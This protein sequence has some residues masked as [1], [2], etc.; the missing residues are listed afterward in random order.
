M[1]LTHV[2]NGDPFTANQV[3]GIMD[4]IQNVDAGHAHSGATDDGHQIS[5]ADLTDGV[6]SGRTNSHAQIDA[7]VAAS[8]GIHGL[9]ASTKLQGTISS[10]VYVFEY[11]RITVPGPD[12]LN[13]V[14]ITT[15]LSTLIGVL[16]TPH[17]DPNG[18]Q[19]APIV[20]SKLLTNAAGAST[21]TVKVGNTSDQQRPTIPYISW[22]A[23]GTK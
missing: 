13:D 10:T 19:A 1:A 5:H 7:H 15:T 12:T 17:I 8:T 20:A 6:I 18:M 23:W 2:A 3:N 14:I 11:G 21:I 9:G 22:A 4:F 16:L